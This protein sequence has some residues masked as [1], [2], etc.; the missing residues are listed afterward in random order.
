MRWKPGMVVH[1]C[2]PSSQ[3]TEERDHEFEASPGY[4]ARPCLKK[5]EKLIRLKT[6]KKT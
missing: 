6:E 5:I 4:I 2:N 1:A 3:E